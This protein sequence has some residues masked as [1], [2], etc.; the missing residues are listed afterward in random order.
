MGSSGL[1]LSVQEP[2]VPEAWD[3]PVYQQ[4][5]KDQESGYLVPLKDHRALAQALKELLESP[6][7]A[8][9]FGQSASQAALDY[10][11]PV[12]TRKIIRILYG[13]GQGEAL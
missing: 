1:M 7:K 12:V 9:Q 8:A 13:D 11:W 3:T 4:L 6:Q 10:D 5:V 2:Y